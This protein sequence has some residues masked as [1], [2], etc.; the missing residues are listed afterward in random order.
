MPWRILL[1]D[2]SHRLKNRESDRFKA[3]LP[4]ARAA[5]RVILLSGTPAPNCSA[6]LWAQLSLILPVQCLPSF[7]EF[8][9]RYSTRTESKR[10]GVRW[11]GYQN[12]AELREC[13]LQHVLIQR[14]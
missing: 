4:I 7:E 3:I 9:D 11:K 12:P 10:F 6:E 5:S 13:C 14:R 1:C 2:E 8:A